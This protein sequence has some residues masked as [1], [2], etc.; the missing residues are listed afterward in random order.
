MGRI[1][2]V[3]FI[4]SFVVSKSLAQ[5]TR[6]APENW[7]ANIQTL[8]KAMGDES[9]AAD[10]AMLISDDAQIRE[11]GS[12]QNDTRYRLL[13]RTG[14]LSVISARVYSGAIET[15]ASDL[16]EDLKACDAMPANMK[17]QFTP[18]DEIE[19]KKANA[20]AKQWIGGL[21]NPAA[22][23]LVAVIVLWQPPVVINTANVLLGTPDQELKEPLFVIIRGKQLPNGDMKIAQIAFGD[24]RQAM[25]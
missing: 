4:A 5:T 20:V 22:G 2:Y 23:E 21:L 8:A 25:K 3:A 17:K 14:G 13:Q 7:G 15:A 11:F 12:N 6:P 9:G 19:A 24:A 1:L 16:G 18:R 10:A